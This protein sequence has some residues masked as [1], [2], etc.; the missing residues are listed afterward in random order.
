MSSQLLPPRRR[1]HGSLDDGKKK[2]SLKAGILKAAQKIIPVFK[3]K[4]RA[5][6]AKNTVSSIQRNSQPVLISVKKKKK[7]ARTN[8]SSQQ[9]RL[10]PGFIVSDAPEDPEDPQTEQPRV[11]RRSI[12]LS[13][14]DVRKNLLGLVEGRPSDL[15][16]STVSS[17]SSSSFSSPRWTFREFSLPSYVSASGSRRSSITS[18]IILSPN[19]SGSRGS[20]YQPRVNVDPEDALDARPSQGGGEDEVGNL[21]FDMAKMQ[22]GGATAL[23]SKTGEVVVTMDPQTLTHSELAL[24]TDALQVCSKKSREGSGSL[25]PPSFSSLGSRPS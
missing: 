2:R 9:I 3:R 13:L 5:R 17:A 7:P 14:K 4:K 21:M 1:R 8:L 25:K 12:S 10:P 19:S 23:N 18:D 15:E 20:R 6:E 11:K 16:T 22:F 24:L